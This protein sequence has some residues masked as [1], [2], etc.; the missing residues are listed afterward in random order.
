M[1]EK[2]ISSRRFCFLC[3]LRAGIP[4]GGKSLSLLHR[5]MIGMIQSVEKS[6]FFVEKFLLLLVQSRQHFLHNHSFNNLSWSFV[7]HGVNISKRTLSKLKPLFHFQ[8]I[9]QSAE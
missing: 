1:Q 7:I 8:C 5:G 3:H 6:Y 2:S 9:N 4:F